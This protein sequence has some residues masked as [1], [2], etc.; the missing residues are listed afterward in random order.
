MSIDPFTLE[1]VKDALVAIGHEMFD[2]MIRTS[3]SPIIYETTD[4]AVGV[5]D[6]RGNLIAQGNGV[7]AFLATLDTAVQSTL[8]RYPAPDYFSP[9]D[10]V[11]TNIPYEGGGTH[12]SD[13][14]IL[15]PVFVGGRLIAWTVNKAHWTEV[16]GAQAGSVSTNASEIYQEGLQFPFVKLYESGRL[17]E[18]LVA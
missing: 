16:G 13:V 4:F 11:I 15:V 9:G 7:T 2:A 6:A 18:A 1:I 14:V 17:N 5:T 3:M 8:E 12:L 10:V